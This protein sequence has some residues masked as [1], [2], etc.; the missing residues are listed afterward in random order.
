MTPRNVTSISAHRAFIYGLCAPGMGETYA[1]SRLRGYLTALF[2]LFFGTWFG[3]TVYKIVEDMVERMVSRLEGISPV[4]SQDFSL[5]SLGISFIAIYCIWLWS[6]I[7][8]VVSATENRRR[9]TEP[10]QAS[11]AWSI[12]MSWFCPG[13]GQV[14][15]GDRRLGYILFA[16][17]IMGILLMIPAYIQLFHGM[18]A[19]ATSDQLS[20]GNPY[21]LINMV[22]ELITR[23]DYS[24]GKLFQ[25]SVKNF[26]LAAALATLRLGPLANDVRWSKPALGSGAALFGIGWLCPGAGQILQK[27]NTV[28]WCLLAGYLGSSILIGFLLSQNFITVQKAETLAWVGIIFQWGAMVEAPLQMLRM[29]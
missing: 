12:T 4:T 1:G 2:F 17:Y 23:V 26:A 25:S 3:W 15:A 6:Q 29:K 28:G 27:R 21:T 18:T 7:S 9:N 20:P 8:A 24:Y 13:A 10:T 16:G 14:Y 5:L 22:R 11:V 19:L